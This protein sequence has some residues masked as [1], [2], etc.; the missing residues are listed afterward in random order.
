MLIWTIFT[1]KRIAFSQ[2]LLALIKPLPNS[3]G[4]AR[5]TSYTQETQ[6][7][8]GS[9][10]CPSVAGQLLPLAIATPCLPPPAKTISSYSQ[11]ACSTPL[12]R[13]T[14]SSKRSRPRAYC[15]DRRADNY[16]RVG[17]CRTSRTW[18]RWSRTEWARS[19]RLISSSNSIDQR[20]KTIIVSLGIEACSSSLQDKCTVL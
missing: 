5:T 6:H 19:K 12:P 14:S 3:N 2:A 20:S 11:T 10:W 7:R 18:N 15:A 8:T 13:T 16:C 1:I 9:A 4:A 17:K